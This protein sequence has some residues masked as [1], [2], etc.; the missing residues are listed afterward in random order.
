MKPGATRRDILRLLELAVTLMKVKKVYVIES[1]S[2][3]LLEDNIRSLSRGF[4]VYITRNGRDGGGRWRREV[5]HQAY[6]FTTM[7]HKTTQ[8]FTNKAVR[9][10]CH[11]FSADLSV[12]SQS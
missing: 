2:D 7:Y 1:T 8:V 9:V 10:F 4:L 12:V 11:Q 5:R 3:Q 6:H